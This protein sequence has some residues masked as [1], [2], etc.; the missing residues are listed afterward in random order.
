MKSSAYQ[1]MAHAFTYA[2]MLPFIYG[3]LA[4][5]G[6]APGLSWWPSWVVWPQAMIV[7]AAVI[8]SFLAGVQWG[9]SLESALSNASSLGL[10]VSANVIAVG[11]WLLLLLGESS[12]AVVGLM[13][14]F[15][16]A[17]AGDYVALRQ[18]D[19]QAWFFSLRWQA[20]LVAM[21][22]LSVVGFLVGI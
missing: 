6:L 5:L 2:G 7:Y 16:V 8:L 18:Q 3:V 22:S 21:L 17:L 10:L 9:R 4:V 12:W 11:V 1:R 14:G 13:L 15:I 19:Q 20:T